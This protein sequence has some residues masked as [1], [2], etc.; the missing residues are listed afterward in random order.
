MK[1][2]IVRFTLLLLF[3]V[4]SA[5]TGYFIWTSETNIN[6]TAET[7]RRFDTDAVTAERAVFELRAS[8]QAYVA[9]GQGEPF[10]IAKVAA[11]TSDLK[12]SIGAIRVHAITPHAQTSVDTALAVLQDFEQM[13]RRARST[14]APASGSWRPISSFRTGL[15]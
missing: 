12:A 9:A 2:V 6:A 4:A 15:N 10:W 5:A 3:L 13:D 8:Q 1:S 11:A 7:A 14:P